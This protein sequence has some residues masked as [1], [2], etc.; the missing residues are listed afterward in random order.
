MTFRIAQYAP[1][2]DFVDAVALTGLPTTEKVDPRLAT[3]EVGEPVAA[4][5][6]N[7]VWHRLT[8][9]ENGVARVYNCDFWPSADYTVYTG[10]ALGEL[11]QVA[12]GEG[13]GNTCANEEEAEF[14]AEEGTTYS[15]RVEGFPGKGFELQTW[16]GWTP[17]APALKESPS[18]LTPGSGST[19]STSSSGAPS[20]QAL[21][22]LRRKKP[23][24]AKPK[25]GKKGKKKA[26]ASKRRRVCKR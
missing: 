3:S 12:S 10:G 25:K 26:K 4:G 13:G 6:G 9:G 5:S 16:F 15:I 23:K 21:T 11:T 22:S 17:E 7:S 19:Q 14:E 8:P 20:P 1:N 18:L 2:D 24:C